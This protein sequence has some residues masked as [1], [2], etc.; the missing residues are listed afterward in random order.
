MYNR[1]EYIITQSVLYNKYNFNV[2]SNNIQC[3]STTRHNLCIHTRANHFESARQSRDESV[4]QSG[5]ESARQ[6]R[7]ESARQSRGESARQARGASPRAHRR[8]ERDPAGVRPGG[9]QQILQLHCIEA[10]T[11]TTHSPTNRGCSRRV[12]T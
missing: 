10:I 11:A 4:R 9:Q 2:C 12:C 5:D 7:D 1:C 8:R 6:S 3:T